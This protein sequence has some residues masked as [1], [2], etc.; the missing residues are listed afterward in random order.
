[1][2]YQPVNILCLRDM[3]SKYMVDVREIIIDIGIL[4]YKNREY[5]GSS[6]IVKM[7]YQQYLVTIHIS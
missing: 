6:F 5:F 1:M 2:K 7:I 3:L 4:R